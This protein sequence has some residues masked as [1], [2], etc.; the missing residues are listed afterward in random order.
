MTVTKNS[1]DR[2][3]AGGRRHSVAVLND[4]RSAVP[5]VAVQYATVACLRLLPKSGGLAC[6]ADGGATAVYHGFRPVKLSR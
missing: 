3:H 1:S 2:S 5:R 4:N 6:A